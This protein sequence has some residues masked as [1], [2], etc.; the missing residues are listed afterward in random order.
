M[1][2]AALT[3]NIIRAETLGTSG[4]VISQNPLAPVPGKP[5]DLND[6]ISLLFLK[7]RLHLRVL[8][9]NLQALCFNP[10]RQLAASVSRRLPGQEA[11]LPPQA[12]ESSSYQEI[13]FCLG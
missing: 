7:V 5:H 2:K 3:L 1:H 8:V 12:A 6:Y 11:T 13:Y 10:S 4:S 9:S